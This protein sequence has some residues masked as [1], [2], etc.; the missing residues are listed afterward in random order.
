MDSSGGT[1][2]RGCFPLA[3]P[4]RRLGW[5]AARRPQRP[6]HTASPA[7]SPPRSRASGPGAGDSDTE[8]TGRLRPA[9]S[10]VAPPRIRVS[11]FGRTQGQSRPVPSVTASRRAHEPCCRRVGH[12][13]PWAQ[14]RVTAAGRDQP[15]RRPAPP[16]SHTLQNAPRTGVMGIAGAQGR[17]PALSPVE[18]VCARARVCVCVCAGGLARGAVFPYAWSP[19]QRPASGRPYTRVMI[20][21][22][23][24]TQRPSHSVDSSDVPPAVPQHRFVAAGHPD[25]PAQTAFSS[26]SQQDPTH[27]CR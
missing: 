2:W 27:P 12:R 18:S 19:A 21:F 16:T 7:T 26:P 17:R 24:A 23:Q 5:A 11:G 15:T 10:G 1:G 20:R 13:R 9:G 25:E 3:S 8:C 4:L 6:H 22:F 14:T